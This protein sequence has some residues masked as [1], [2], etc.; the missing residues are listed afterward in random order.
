MALPLAALIFDVDG[1]LA[2]TEE[3]HRL[4]FNQAFQRHGVPWEWDL[5]LYKSLLAISGGK[6]RMR[7]YGAATD[8]T[9]LADDRFVALASALHQTK[10]ELY[11]QM[12]AQ[13]GVPLRPGVLDLVEQ[14]RGAGLRLAIATTTTR[15]N[16]NALLD[17]ATHGAGHAW[18]EVV[19]CSDDAP[20]KKPDPQVYRLV[21]ERL[22]LAA[23]ACLAIED[24]LN[25]VMA[26]QRAGIPVVV[27]KSPFTESPAYPGAL[28]VFSDLTETSLS[29]LDS[30]R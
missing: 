20:V 30:L 16:V 17:G 21:L 2:E 6:E 29:H 27:T 18:F 23:Q 4:A 14:A 1:T 22:T 7:A 28:R 19:A 11:T 24:S 15:A 25:G 8:P 26:A 9:R 13:G 10:T 12:V 3:A 5:P